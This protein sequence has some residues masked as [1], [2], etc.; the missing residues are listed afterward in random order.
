MSYEEDEELGT[1]LMSE[2]NDDE[3]LEEIPE[4]G[5]EDFGL[6][7]EDPDKDK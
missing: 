3:P 5:I 4:E 1:G 2:L 6:E 7:E